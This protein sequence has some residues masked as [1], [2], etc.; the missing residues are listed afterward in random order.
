MSAIKSFLGWQTT[1]KDLIDEAKKDNKSPA[2]FIKMQDQFTALAN[3]IEGELN[4]A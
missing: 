1:T 4:A 2:T 3:T